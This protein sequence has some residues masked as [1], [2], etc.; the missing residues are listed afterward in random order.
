MLKQE[1]LSFKN[2]VTSPRCSQTVPTVGMGPS[3][4]CTAVLSVL[5]RS[6]TVTG[7]TELAARAAW[8]ASVE[9]FVSTVPSFDWLI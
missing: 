2:R 4:S 5:A 9:V 1:E 6:R 3:A 7:T 8:R